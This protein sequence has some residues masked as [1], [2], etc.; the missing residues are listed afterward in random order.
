MACTTCINIKIDTIIAIHSD[1]YLLLC[2]YRDGRYSK[3]YYEQ[4]KNRLTQQAVE[5]MNILCPHCTQKY[6]KTRGRRE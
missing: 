1:L 2:L 3:K 6:L 4:H 5:I